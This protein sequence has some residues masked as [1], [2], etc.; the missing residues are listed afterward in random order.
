MMNMI[1]FLYRSYV[2]NAASTN[3]ALA[4]FHNLDR[5]KIPI[6]VVYF[7]PDR[8]KSKVLEQFQYIK[9]KYYW[10]KF[11]INHSKL[12][13]LSFYVY[14]KL[15]RHSLKIGDKVYVYG[16]TELCEAALKKKNV[17][18]FFEVTECPEVSF[19]HTPIYKPSLKRHYKLCQ[20]VNALFVISNHLKDY[21]FSK[22]VSKSRIHTINMVVDPARFENL[23]KV[24]SS[25]QYIAYCGSATNNKDGVDELIKAFSI[26]SKRHKDVFL[27]IIG[28]PPKEGE[29]G[30]NRELARMLG[31]EDKVVFTG[32]LPSS[33]V[34][35]ILK[36]ALVLALDRPDNKQAKYGFPTK[37]G[38]YLLTGN[39]VVIT[40]VGDIPSFF[41]D[42]ESA[43]IAPPNNPSAFAEKL[44]WI[45]EN[46][47]AAARIG[48]NGKDIALNYFNAETETQ[49]LIKV[50]QNMTV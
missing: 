11:Y 47:A 49:K 19:P 6:T 40:E 28:P 7:L 39:P 16:Q 38:E 43:C 41:K 18:V 5:M 30:S 25:Y 20:S 37:L 42:G 33:Q 46:P 14:T 15:F 48:G 9:F 24:P 1:Y 4:Y 45:V 27:Y 22:G 2:P 3:R 32:I 8:D 44:C 26:F 13:Y 23:E 31:V 36:N 29:Q 35:Q 17:E 34:P 12:R 21:Y 50:I 10:D